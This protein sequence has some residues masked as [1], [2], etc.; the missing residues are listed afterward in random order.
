MAKVTH[1]N[2]TSQF[3]SILSSNQY[4]VVD[5]HAV[6]CGPCHMIDP[7]FE[8]LASQHAKAGSLAFVKVD[9]DQQQEIAATYGITAMPT[10]LVIKNGNVTQT[11]RGANP[12]ALNAAV[13]N[14]VADAAKSAP[15]PQPAAETKTETANEE[16]VSGSY[17]ITKGSGW[18]MS[19]N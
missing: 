15:K 5:F 4:V 2:S 16:T 19:L 10:F 3:Q 6:W 11:I 13:R 12:P 18:K 17:G 9:V 14:V 8:Q 1:I 7:V